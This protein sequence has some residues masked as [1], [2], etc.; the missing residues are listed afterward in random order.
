M[1]KGTADPYQDKVLRASQGS[2]FHIPVITADLKTF[3]A[4]FNGPVY[5]CA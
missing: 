3:I 4:G 5:D 2:V 1:E